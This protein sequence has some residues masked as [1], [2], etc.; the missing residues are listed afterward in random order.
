MGLFDGG[1][2]KEQLTNMEQQ[3]RI[4]STSIEAINQRLSSTDA[5]AGGYA[6]GD[7]HRTSELI[8]KMADLK[9]DI[10]GNFDSINQTMAKLKNDLEQFSKE[11]DAIKGQVMKLNELIGSFAAVDK[12]WLRL[13]IERID[14][15]NEN[16]GNLN[17][18][19][20]YFHKNLLERVNEKIGDMGDIVANRLTRTALIGIGVFVGI[21]ILFLILKFVLFPG[22]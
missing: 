8:E 9:K 21:E 19:L 13:L 11:K 6:A 16:S 22:G 14:K 18:N 5:V 7:V 10:A 2:K 20:M 1:E 17:D 3:I 15:F 4:L 12:K